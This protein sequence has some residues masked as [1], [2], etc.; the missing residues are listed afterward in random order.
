MQTKCTENT[1]KNENIYTY[2]ESCVSNSSSNNN[3]QQRKNYDQRILAFG[4]KDF[5]R[6]FERMLSK[7]SICMRDAIEAGREEKALRGIPF[8]RNVKRLPQFTGSLRA[9]WFSKYLL[10]CLCI[11]QLF[12]GNCCANV[13]EFVLRKRIH[14]LCPEFGFLLACFICFILRCGSNGDRELVF[15]L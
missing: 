4:G 14:W 3:N 15:Q 2:T 11:I 13:M 6:F 5:D 12:L 9:L 1:Q 7:V 8:R 10:V